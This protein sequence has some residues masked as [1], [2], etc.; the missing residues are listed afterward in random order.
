MAFHNGLVYIYEFYRLSI[1]V[2]NTSSCQRLWPTPVIFYLRTVYIGV[3]NG[4]NASLIVL[5]IERAVCICRISNYEES[6]QP[7]VVSFFL[8][9]L[10]IIF[11]IVFVF[12]CLPGQRWSTGMAISTT[13]NSVNSTNY[14]AICQ[15][16]IKPIVKNIS[17]SADV[18]SL[19]G[20]R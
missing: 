17:G 15:K 1:D 13:R 7:I 11:T 19:H 8:A 4:I 10:T 16:A 5:C 2:T 3:L 12:L 18:S 14:Q 6:R 9:I 20:I